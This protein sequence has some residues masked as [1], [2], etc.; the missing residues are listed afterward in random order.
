VSGEIVQMP[1]RE[2]QGAYGYVMENMEGARAFIVAVVTE[3]EQFFLQTFGPISPTEEAFASV[4]LAEA[5]LMRASGK[6]E[7]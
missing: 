4:R 2:K 7:P 3:D 6:A 5:S 1:T